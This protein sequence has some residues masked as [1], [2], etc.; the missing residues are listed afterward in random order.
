MTHNLF[1]ILVCQSLVCVLVIQHVAN[2]VDGVAVPLVAGGVCFQIHA[3]FHAEM[4]VT[5]CE[6]LHG[7]FLGL[8]KLGECFVDE[9]LI[10][11]AESMTEI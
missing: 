2:G 1:T 8:G 11:D 5:H 6:V 7:D 9:E 4:I 3:S 10:H